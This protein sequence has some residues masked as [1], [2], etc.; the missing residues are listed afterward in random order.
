MC[1]HTASVPVTL[2]PR[3]RF[4]FEGK[5][6]QRFSNSRLPPQSCTCLHMS[7]CCW[8]VASRVFETIWQHLEA[9]I[10]FAASLSKEQKET[11]H[12][13]TFSKIKD[14]LLPVSQNEDFSKG[15]EEEHLCL[16]LVNFNGFLFIWLYRLDMTRINIL[17]R[18]I[19]ASLQSIG[20]AHLFLNHILSLHGAAAPPNSENL[21]RISI[22]LTSRQ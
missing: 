7:S 8:E 4:F 6:K 3:H 10:S 9:H 2:W 12:S 17:I 20:F 11:R 19:N 14:E 16:T 15:K 13:H 21:I 1:L 22:R 5:T 18:F